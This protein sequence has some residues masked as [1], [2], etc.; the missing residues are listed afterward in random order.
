[1]LTPSQVMF[2]EMKWLT[3]PQR[4]QYHTCVMVYKA[5]HS[6]APEYITDLS[7]KTSYVHNR[8]LR[9][10]NN[11]L[12]HIPSFRTSVY[13]NSFSVSAAQLWNTIPL[14]VRMSNNLASFK[15]SMKKL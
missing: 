12:S 10:V 1:M 6:M 3:F 8:N 9:T 15:T 7:T 4:V 2:I 11:Q 5:L 14:A 13:E